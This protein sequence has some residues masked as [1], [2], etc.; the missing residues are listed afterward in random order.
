MPDIEA[1]HFPLVLDTHIWI[2]LLEDNP[3]LK[4]SPIVRAVEL[5]GKR[6]Q[7]RV[8]I[9]SVWEIGML[10]AKG[11]LQLP[12]HP[13]EWVHKALHISLVLVAPL[14]EEIVIE[15]SFLPG[16]F[17]GDPMDRI[18]I[19]TTRRLQGTLVTCD[20]QIRDYAK[21]HSLPTLS[22]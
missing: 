8:S 16:D 22:L 12:C 14:T 9:M 17:H 10:E 6:S 20:R 13:L 21:K 19:A 15:S 3:R 4:G 7:V 18:L 1:R 5:A 11:R 2:W